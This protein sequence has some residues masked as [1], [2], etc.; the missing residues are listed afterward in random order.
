MKDDI[1]L[2]KYHAHVWNEPLIMEM[3]RTGET[4]ITIPSIEDEINRAVGEVHDYIPSTM[5]RKNPPRLPELSQPHVLRHYLRLSQET[6][7][8]ALTIDLGQGTCTMKYSPLINEELVRIP[9]FYDTHPFQ[10]E[11]TVQGILEI[12]YKF[13]RFLGEISGM[14]EFTFQPGGGAHGVFTN[15]CI[16]RKFHEVR[17]E[18]QER[19]EVITTVLS[20]PSNAGCPATAG[21]KVLNL[22]PDPET[23]LPDIEALK[24][25]ASKH[26]AGL[27]ITNPEDTG[28]FNPQIDE[29]VK[30]IHEVGGLCAYDQANSNALFGIARARDAGFDMCQFNIHK[31]FSSPHASIGPGCGAVGVTKDLEEYLPVPIVT[32]DRSTYHLDYDRPNSIGKVR[33][34]LGNVENVLR[35]YAWLMTMGAEG[36]VQVSETSV[37]NTN[38]LIKKMST[39]PGV[40]MAYPKQKVRLDQVRFSLE[41]LKEETGV[42]TEDV[43]RRMVDFGVQEYFE[44]HHPWIVPEPFIPEPC[45]TYS[46]EDIDYW[47]ATIDHVCQEAY[48]NPQAV[49]TAPHEQPISRIKQDELNDSKKYALTWRAYLQKNPN[50][51]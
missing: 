43:A 14:D 20:H 38:Y 10:N 21:F 22:Y 40:T 34:F 4:G 18:L 37:M 11:Q 3:G 9:E 39:V 2:R 48:S 5:Q 27:F 35:A 25:A 24:A 31:A 1:E 17:G 49:M 15:A 42:G 46:K 28:I 29:Y 8:M 6:L 44:S 36:L 26:T 13:A 12:M 47:V 51:K 32:F 30:L 23:G 16:I 45:E 19:N 50:R 33:Q 7:G 41:K